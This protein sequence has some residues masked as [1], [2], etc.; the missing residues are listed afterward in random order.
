MSEDESRRAGAQDE[1]TEDVEG[2]GHRRVTANDDA[3][4][5]EATEGDDD[6]EAH[7]HRRVQ[8]RRTT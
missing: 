2:H 3:E 7:G 1:E 4:G 5:S 8:Q 6:F